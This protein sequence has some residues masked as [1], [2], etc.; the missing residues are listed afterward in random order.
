MQS[1]TYHVRS[2]QI[3]SQREQFVDPYRTNELTI[4]FTP[5]LN[6]GLLLINELLLI[7][8]DSPRWVAG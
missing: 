2:L 4:G 3:T 1:A 6:L 5:S 7:D 8:G